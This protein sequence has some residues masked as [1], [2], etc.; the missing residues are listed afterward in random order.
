MGLTRTLIVLISSFSQSSNSVAPLLK[1]LA[2][3]DSIFIY[4]RDFVHIYSLSP[5]VV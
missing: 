3:T 4:Q 5:I 1:L 2:N